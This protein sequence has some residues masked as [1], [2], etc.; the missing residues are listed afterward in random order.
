MFYKSSYT[1]GM[2]F[3]HN[4]EKVLLQFWPILFL[5]K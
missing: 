4:W 2:L 3:N 1:K 5:I